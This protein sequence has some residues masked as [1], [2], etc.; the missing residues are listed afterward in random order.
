M[1]DSDNDSTCKK[2]CTLL[3]GKEE[4]D[5]HLLLITNVKTRNTLQEKIRHT[6]IKNMIWHH[7]TFSWRFNEPHGINQHLIWIKRWQSRCW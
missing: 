7:R 6:C 4:K 5:K 1:T 2:I 3:H